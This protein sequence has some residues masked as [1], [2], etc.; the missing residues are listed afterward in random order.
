[1]QIEP[2][3]WKILEAI[4][5]CLLPREHYLLA[6]SGGADSLALADAAAT[7]YAGKLKL[8]SVCHVEHGIRGQEALRDAEI[9][10]HFCRERGLSFSCCHV[11]VPEYASRNGYT[12][13]EAA[14]K[15]R[16]EALAAEAGRVGARAVV[17]AHQADDQVENFLWKLLRGAGADGLSGM[18]SV[19]HYGALVIL[20]PLL[21]FNRNDLEQYCKLRGLQ[22]C[23]DSSNADPAY[24]RNRIRNRLLPYL[25]QEYNPAVREA[26]LHAS[27][28]LAEEQECLQTFVEKHL[29]DST[30]C[31]ML[32]RDTNNPVWWIAA[33]A[34]KRLPPAL[35]KRILRE[36]CFAMGVEYLSYERTNALDRLCTTGTGGKLVQLPEGITASYRNKKI[37][38]AKGAVENEQGY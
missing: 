13:E 14:R 30:F 21:E 24:T 11:A 27:H 25:E 2:G 37:F 16:Y 4:K 12:L 3:V 6:V 32:N 22:F 7:V 34:L 19:S 9:V 31:G 23:T 18:K 20:R 28:T 5:A 8:L 1:M 17:T 35:R 26:L 10:E 33:P 29:Q 15:L 36:L 38:I